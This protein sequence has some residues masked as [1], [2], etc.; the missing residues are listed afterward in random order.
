MPK[1]TQEVMTMG[2]HEPIM[3]FSRALILLGNAIW[4]AFA[5]KKG[6]K[7][8]L[9]KGALGGGASICISLL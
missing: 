1:I 9:R 5:F 4:F 8:I 6:R 3:R 2:G 7:K